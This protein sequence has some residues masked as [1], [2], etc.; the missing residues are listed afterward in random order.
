MRGYMLRGADR[1]GK[2]ESVPEM[3]GAELNPGMD[4]TMTMW[5]QLL[6]L[7][8]FTLTIIAELC[9]GQC[10]TWGDEQTKGQTCWYTISV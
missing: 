5:A 3:L 7:L 2:P 10:G 1:D 4:Y 8:V 6:C 9:T